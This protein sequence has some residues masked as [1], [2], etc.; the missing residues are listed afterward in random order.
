MPAVATPGRFAVPFASIAG[1]APYRSKSTDIR[2]APASW[3][4]YQHWPQHPD[5]ELYVLTEDIPGHTKTS[6]VSRATLEE[7]GFFV[8]PPPR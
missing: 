1:P 8:P 4:G 6:T 7:A 2:L 5:V 3:L